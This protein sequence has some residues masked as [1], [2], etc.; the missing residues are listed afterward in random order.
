MMPNT[1]RQFDWFNL[2]GWLSIN[3]PTGE[4]WLVHSYS[5]M[6]LKL[7]Q[8]WRFMSTHSGLIWGQWSSRS[9][10][11]C[12]FG[13]KDC[14]RRV[15]TWSRKSIPKLINFNNH[16]KWPFLKKKSSELFHFFTGKIVDR[17][18]PRTNRPKISTVLVNIGY[19]LF[20]L[21][22]SDHYWTTL[23]HRLVFWL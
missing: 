3:W 4:L 6:G 11:V 16:Q 20:I 8:E 10:P 13:V 1:P 22:I 17:G 21:L 14:N 15:L 7:V 2:I 5:E 12:G 19:L 18:W 9:R 23:N